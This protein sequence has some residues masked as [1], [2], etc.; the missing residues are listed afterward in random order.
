M[1]KRSSAII[2]AISNSFCDFTLNI[3]V[4]KYNT[5]F[6]LLWTTVGSFVIQLIYGFV[7]GYSCTIE[8]I[9]YIVIYGISMLLGYIFYILALWRLPVSLVA[10]IESSG[11]FGYFI[12]DS[13]CGYLRVNLWFCFLF[14]LFMFSIFL[15]LCDDYK[16]TDGDIRKKIKISGILILLVSMFFDGMEP[17]LIKFASNSGANEITI[18][19]GYYFFAIPAFI[20]LYIKNK[21]SKIKNI[22][23]KKNYNVIKYV[24]LISIFEAIY[25]LFGTIGY[26][27][28]VASINAIIQEIRV[29]LLFILSIITGADKL[30]LEKMVAIIIGMLSL[31][32]IYLY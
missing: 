28:E 31:V 14:V 21:R 16:Y 20:V 17:Y 4:N 1:N 11:L 7:V 13:I 19:M 5:S 18:N 27:E 9:F 6:I 29:F 10:L 3:A 2:S 12:V 26:I 24:L 23:C 22:G 8:A 15:F 25:S 30:T 32:G